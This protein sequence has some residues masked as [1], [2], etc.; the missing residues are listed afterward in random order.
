LVQGR[1]SRKY[2]SASSR[3]LQK[4][5]YGQIGQLNLSSFGKA[6]R[7]RKTDSAGPGQYVS[8]KS[9]PQPLLFDA[10]LGFF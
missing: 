3:H 10:Q 8:G 4:S 5:I 9:E 6:L 1:A 7:T 2:H